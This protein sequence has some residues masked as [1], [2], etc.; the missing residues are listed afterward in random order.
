MCHFFVYNFFFWVV[1]VITYAPRETI[2]FFPRDSSSGYKLHF[3]KNDA[4]Q[5]P[6]VIPILL[7][8]NF[9]L[10][11]EIHSGNENY[12]WSEA[13]NLENCFY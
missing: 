4:F 2:L 10:K 9:N 12:F 7:Q 3:M 11:L 6:D 13:L 8:Y 5:S 1:K